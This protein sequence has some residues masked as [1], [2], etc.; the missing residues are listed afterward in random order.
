M[1]ESP[2]AL[3]RGLLRGKR[4]YQDRA[5]VL[6]AA[7][8]GELR[9]LPEGLQ[10]ISRTLCHGMPGGLPGWCG[11]HCSAANAMSGIGS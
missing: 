7:I 6:P 8:M 5:A 1:L 10:H 2:Q 4:H 11:K 9:A 3:R